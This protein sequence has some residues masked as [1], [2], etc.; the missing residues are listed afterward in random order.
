MRQRDAWAVAGAAAAAAAGVGVWAR[1]VEPRLLVTRRRTVHPPGWPPELDGLRVAVIADLHAG[2]HR[3]DIERVAEVVAV[4]NRLHPDLIAILGDVVDA[5]DTARPDAV[6]SRLAA[7]EAPLGVVGVLG[8]HDRVSGAAR[9]TRALEAAGVTL[10]E[11]RALELRFNDAPLWVVGVSDS[12]E[13]QPDVKA[14]FAEVPPDARAL[15]I[16][17]SPD[18]FPRLPDQA[19]LTLAGHTHGGQVAIPGLR[20][21]FIPSRFGARYARGFVEERRRLLFVHPGIGTSRWRLRLGARPEV[22]LLTL[23]AYA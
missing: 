11:D 5:P 4:A 14:A 18:A 7:L 21:R 3:A 15:V 13:R 9:V 8:N 23:R 20:A 10:L 19:A 1:W 2:K 17:H 12:H 22:T 6:G 16:T